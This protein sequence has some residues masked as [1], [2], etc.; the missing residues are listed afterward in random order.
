MKPS[1]DGDRKER[2]YELITP[3]RTPTVRPLR[4]RGLDEAE[5]D[6]CAHKHVA[7]RGSPNR[8]TN[9]CSN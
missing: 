7:K 6:C 2:Q 8:P 9:A 5:Y 1:S 3:V 4:G